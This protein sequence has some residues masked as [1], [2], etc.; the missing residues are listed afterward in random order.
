MNVG[1]PTVVG[2]AVA[3]A[4]RTGLRVGFADAG[5]RPPEVVVVLRLPDRDARVGHGDVDE[6]E[7]P[8][9]LARS[10]PRSAS[11]SAPR[12]GCRAAAART[13]SAC[14]RRPSR[15][16]QALRLGAHGR[17]RHA[18]AAEALHLLER[19]G[20][21][22]ARHR[23][24]AAERETG[25][26]ERRTNGVTSPQCAPSASGIRLTGSWRQW[27]GWLL[28][29]WSM[30]TR[31][32]ACC[33]PSFARS[34]RIAAAA[35]RPTSM[36][37][38]FARPPRGSACRSSARSLIEAS[39]P[40]TGTAPPACR[41]PPARSPRRSEASP[42][43][44]PQ[45]GVAAVA[46]ARSRSPRRTS[47][48]GRSPWPGSSGPARAARRTRAVS[49]GATGVWSRPLASIAIWFQRSSRSSESAP[50]RD[51]R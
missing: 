31:G 12:S 18:V 23:R 3:R 39:P 16:R 44:G 2:I 29:M 22:R 35:R 43:R 5:H 50:R 26:A 10:V 37:C 28:G 24:A 6:R 9:H 36:P 47:R 42:G 41:A 34:A 25:R 40:A 7:Q 11:R 46:A 38:A 19:R 20:V 49:P 15:C 45:T 27:P 8:R 14:R 13:G 4:G 17:R 32:S 21:L 1:S 51:G 30:P 48:C 33:E